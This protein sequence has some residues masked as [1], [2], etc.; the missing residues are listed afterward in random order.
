MTLSTLDI[1]LKKQGKIYI[2]IS[3]VC[4]IFATIY[5]SFSH[6][7]YSNFMI[8]AFLI[9]FI[10]GTCVSVALL[11]MNEL[12]SRITNNLYNASIATFTF[13]SIIKGV[14][15]IYGTT[16]IKIYLYLVVGFF[17]FLCSLISFAINIIKQ[18]D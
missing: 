9:P 14:L 17:L 3:I 4:I 16:N 6:G 11:K 2:V 7:V 5:E 8:F 1:N 10:G 13:G 15:E 18:E 12:P